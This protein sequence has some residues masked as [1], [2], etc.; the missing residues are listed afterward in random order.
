MSNKKAVT[1]KRSNDLKKDSKMVVSPQNYLYALIVFV[2][3]ILLALY[4]FKWYQ[5]KKEER[6]MNS[7]LITTSTIASSVN[8]LTSLSQVIKE[9]PDS[10][11]IYFGYTKDEEVYNLEKDL[12]KIIDKYKL[13]DIFYYVN[14]TELKNKDNNYIEEIKSILNI[15]N[16]KNIP[17][18]IYVHNGEIKDE[19]ILDG[20]KDTKFKATD[21][22]SLLDIYEFEAIK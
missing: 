7:Y 12:K 18:V 3:I 9:A 21:L 11:F 20:V 16:L 22:Q 8:D 2:G 15:D 6:L 19:N 1:K 17:A 5:V 14:V 4:F 10:Y 13:N